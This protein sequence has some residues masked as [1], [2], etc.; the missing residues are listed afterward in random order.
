M[1]VNFCKPKIKVGTEMVTK[2][3][4]VDKTIDNVSALA[5]GLFD[6]LFAFLVK[7]CN[8]TLETGL[9]RAQ[10]I[11]VLDI[12]GFEIFDF[13]GF[14]QISIN[15]TNEKLQ[16]F[17]NHHMFVLE[18]EE[19]KKEGI[20]WQFID[21][22]M[23]LQATITLF[24]MKMGIWSILE[25]ESMFPKATDKTFAEKLSGH[26]EGK[27]KPFLKP[28]GNA[29]FGIQHYAGV[30]N[31]NIT[32]W[33][34]KNKDPL[35]DTVIDQLKKG[36]NELVVMLF[37][38]HAGQ[39]GEPDQ[40]GGKK[41]SG[42]FKTVVSAYRD[43]LGSLMNILHSTHPHFIR[44][45]VPNTVKTP[46]KV[47]AGL[48]M[49]QLTCNG[50]LEGIRICQLGLP[51]RMIYSDFYNRYKI[52]GASEFNSITD[53]K[54]AVVAVFDKLGLDAEKYRVGATKVFF[55]AGVLGEV[56]EIRDD[57]LG[58][59]VSWL[60]AWVRG[61][62]S[63]RVYKKLQAQR[64]N[65]L[66]VQRNLRKY[67]NLRTWLWYGFWQQL[68]PKLNV[69][70]EAEMIA[71]LEEAAAKA[72]LNVVIAN[73]KNV[74]FGAENE[75]LI[76]QK[77]EL[78]NALES[79][80]CGASDFLDKEAKMMAQKAEVEG[81]LNE[82]I[83]RLENEEDAKNSLAQAVRKTEQE[84]D[85][86]KTDIEDMDGC[87]QKATAEKETKEAQLRNLGEEINHQE[88]L[89]AKSNKDK[90]A[91]Q[92]ANQRSGE[93]YQCLEDK[94]QHLNKIKAKL[95][96]NLDEL[97]D[98]L[99]R[100][101]KLRSDGE[102]AKRKIDGDLK[103]TQEA[104]SDLERN[105]K[106][107]ENTLSRKENE[108]AALGAKIDDEALGTARTGKQAK[109]LM[110]RIEELEDDLKAEAAARA[111]SEK[112]KQALAREVEE[113]GD[114]LDEAGGATAAQVELNKK[115]E[116]DLAK[117]RRDLEEANLQHEAT[118]GSLRKKHNDA[119][120]EMSEQV[121]Y[122]NKMKAR[123]EKDKE[124]IR[125]E[126]D[127]AKSALD[128]LARDK[129]A[130]EKTTKQI[131]FN[132]EDMSG[133]LDEA[134]RTLNDFDATK[135]RM[136]A[137]NADLIRQLEEAESQLGSLSKM[138][139]SLTNQYEDSR[140]MA[141]DESRERATL[142]GKFRNLEHDINT[143]REQLDEESESK[144]DVHRQLS[145][146]NADI[147]MY[148][149]QYESEGVARAEEIDASRQKLQSRLDEAEQQIDS[150]S[151]KNTSLEKAKNRIINDL[152]VMQADCERA[153]TQAAS[154]E[155][156]QKNFDK[157]ISEWKMKVDDLAAELDASQ[158]ECRNYSTELFRIKAC[159][160]ENVETCDGMKRENKNLSEEVKDLMDQIGEG[161]R[162]YHEV[163]K[164][165][166]RLEVEKEELQN[167]LEE[168]E[169]ALEQEEN[170]VLRGQLEISQVRQEIDR[171]IAEKEE[172]F[173]NTRKTHARAVE[174]IQA[175]LEAESKSKAEALRSKKRLEADINE[176]E[177]SLD[178]ANKS[179]SD[180]QKHIKKLNLETKGL[181]DRI[182][183]HHRVASEYTEQYGIA[184]RRAN[185]LHS[186]LEDSRAML[187]QSDRSRRQIELDLADGSEQAQTLSSQN[188][189]LAL[190]RRK[191]ENEMQ[192]L[193]ADLDEMLNETKHSEEKAKK[194]MIDAARLADELRSEQEHVS[195][196][197]KVRKTLEQTVKEL[198]VRF[199]DAEA[200]ATR[201]GKQAIAK[202]EERVKSLESELQSESTRHADA[203]KNV[204]KCERR[205]KELTFQSE[206]DKK[207]QDRMQDLVDNLQIKIKTYKRQI[208]EAEEV[209]A[210]NLAKFRK[211]Q[212][213]LESLEAH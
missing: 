170:K 133:K 150:L 58:K 94:C 85:S 207:N 199:E 51:N 27:S 172:E 105:Q 86:L 54:K 116:A 164:N 192:T 171:R 169:A 195:Q 135:K 208:E 47:E 56:E 104:V 146:A 143:M 111:K 68:K 123:T 211:S 74:K 132:L 130:A 102:K 155:K 88:E 113:I 160:E 103:L 84:V 100:E 20:V 96:Q 174:S 63:R 19:Y 87:L 98:S 91:L 49:H 183:E 32:G 152:E 148:R 182:A 122:L 209:A 80:K 89:I 48:I 120:A 12:A 203:V 30:V 46:G 45:I 181:Q 33:L 71:K 90:K 149:A 200:T 194:A 210:L 179:N 67:M 118:L 18:Q 83:K 4:N 156:K 186:E 139:L 107:L 8:E 38:N 26:H 175:S 24:E 167:A 140:R 108:V 177:I 81:Q 73:E 129:V 23:D 125:R 151:F 197:E 212:Q 50:V 154:A 165:M 158:K 115:R 205:I 147:Q 76:A 14:E 162:N 178:H 64:V 21:F 31:Y 180:L 65:L 9:K 28:K 144:A 57:R 11:G 106:E 131:Q 119:I 187:E 53:K 59:M 196:I 141:D 52:L 121:D 3:Q 93:D 95:E 189:A 70:R 41:K 127:D 77:N 6:R 185:A 42:G 35:N 117:F 204:R 17:F 2:G 10:F 79:S 82:A 44:C 161:G 168:A 1:Y 39:S 159:Y 97:E 62:K 138:K 99:E 101:K 184:E 7:K 15:F 34:E 163:V 213:E 191:L 22:G 61:W 110:A 128:A 109:E 13:N 202:V 173:D 198:Q 66:V 92:E 55:R 188:N 166:K 16:Q 60:Q 176:M 157:I 126:T 69:G 190:T 137:E 124:T 36:S 153:Q 5:K 72:E 78:L 29:H 206:E 193:S 25:E 37:A 75:V 40:K 134:N 136:G 142:L 145:K 201:S 112:A 43:Q 114:R